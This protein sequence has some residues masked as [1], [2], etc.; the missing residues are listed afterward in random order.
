MAR[1]AARRVAPKP[2]ANGAS[3][4]RELI[5]IAAPDVA[6]RATPRGLASLSGADMSAMSNLLARAGAVVRPLFG[7]S[8][9]RIQGAMAAAAEMGGVASGALPDLSVFYRV[10]G[11]ESRLDELAARL[12]T[13]PGVD[14]AYV[15]PSAQP[16][17]PAESAREVI[18]L[19]TMTAREADA[20]PVT[21]DF[22][23]RQVYLGPAPAGIDAEYGWTLAGGH[24]A[25]VRIIDIE[26]AWQFT[27]EDLTQNQGGV[28]G[29]AIADFDWRNHGT[30]VI[31]VIGGDRNSIGVTGIA[32]D[33]HVRGCSIF[34]GLGS[35]GA[36][37]KA[38]DLLSPGDIIL[39]ELHRPGPN[40]TGVGQQGYIPI[41]WWPDDYAAI[42]YAVTRGV[43]VVEAAGNGAQNLDDP[44][45]DTPQ[46][47][48]PA[49]WRNPFDRTQRDSGA[50]LV[51]AGAPPPGTHGRDHGPDRSRL[52]FSN[53]GSA[54]DVQ[55][56]GREVTTTGYGDLQGGGNENL[57]YTDQFSGTSSASPVVVGAL[58]CVQGA[59]K[60]QQ[61]IALDPT[62]AR[63]LLRATGSPQQDAP[64]RPA[65]QRIGNRPDLRQLVPA[66]LQ[67]NEWIG[68]QFIGTIPGNA[69]QRWFSHSWPAHWHMDWR[70]MPIT[71]R[72][73][74]P[75]LR[76][77]VEV[78][79][80]SEGHATYWIT[81]TNLTPEEVAFEGR[82]AVLG[83]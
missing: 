25:G 40:A 49:D 76:W 32:S 9:E 38:A 19:N 11:P 75:Q 80:A 12:A 73:G 47:G 50:V 60:A 4:E 7:D 35:A 14:G 42:R 63:D 67:Q 6:L 48:F 33:A 68:V 64:G 29:T 3:G 53:Y 77:H 44:V 37:R 56:W 62:R 70:V 43:V 39:I 45:Y 1:K 74:E 16:A 15:K 81:V 17:L 24:G 22:T 28:V 61:R 66:A 57:Y 78:E 23:A 52:E 46:P 59:L 65:T 27:H 72:P 26:G 20:P 41:E 8:E 55:G 83:W 51:G 54:V 36:L 79:R 2:G 34:G 5:V 58:A 21:P 71:P 30:A 18:R 10:E 69:T 13:V 31:G 82:Y